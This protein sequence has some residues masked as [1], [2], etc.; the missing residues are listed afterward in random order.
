MGKTGATMKK[1]KV[2]TAQARKEH[3]EKMRRA[4]ERRRGAKA[5]EEP[6]VPVPAPRS[7]GIEFSRVAL[8][9]A[10]EQGWDTVFYILS[11]VR[12]LAEGEE[13]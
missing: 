12:A 5:K 11:V 9:L 4:W 13:P 3:A 6:S 1:R 10:R 7:L 8:A 2:W